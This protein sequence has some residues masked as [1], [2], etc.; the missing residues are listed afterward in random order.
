MLKV[1][2]LWVFV[3]VLVFVSSLG[4]FAQE[5]TYRAAAEKLLLLMKQDQLVDQMFDQMKQM[6]LQQLEQMN[7]G[8][9]SPVGEKYLERIYGVMKEEMS[10]DKVK[11]DF[12]RIYMTVYTEE[13]ILGLVAFYES[14]LGQ[15]VIEKMPL[16]AQE[17]M[18]ISQK[19]VSRVMPKIQAITQEM[20]T[21]EGN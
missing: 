7:I 10:W 1:V 5:D 2:R 15:K 11:D 6:Q 21:E 8:S 16:M 20:L 14:P 17:S 18:V 4:V 9:E 12:I 19:Y 13:E 3:L